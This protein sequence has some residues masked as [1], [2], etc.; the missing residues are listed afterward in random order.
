MSLSILFKVNN[1]L[2]RV[3]RVSV[4]SNRVPICMMYWQIL[5]HVYSDYKGC[6]CVLKWHWFLHW[7][8][9]TFTFTLHATFSTISVK[10]ILSF[11]SWSTEIFTNNISK[12]RLIQPELPHTATPYYDPSWPSNAT[13]ALGI[14]VNTV[15]GNGMAPSHY[16]NQCWLVTWWCHQTETFSALLAI[17]TRNSP[18]PDEFPAQR[19]VMRSFDVFFNLCLD[20]RLSKQ[21]WGWWFEMLPR[22]LW[23]HRNDQRSFVASTW[24]Q[25]YMKC[26]R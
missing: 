25:Y 15:L 16:L 6:T 14:L 7:I 20:K 12:L 3:R 21:S 1:C 5:S 4:F 9:E 11:K 13:M 19:P 26:S 22:P 17:C 8:K 10:N 23:C 2:W 24:K 18:F